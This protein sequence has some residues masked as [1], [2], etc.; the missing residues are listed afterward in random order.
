MALRPLMRALQP[1]ERVVAFGIAD[2]A[3]PG[4][5]GL[6]VLSGLLPIGSMWSRRLLRRRRV[7]VLTDRRLVVLPPDRPELSERSI[8]W[9]GEF[10]LTQVELIARGKGLV[11]VRGPGVRFVARVRGRWVGGELSTA[12]P[13]AVPESQAR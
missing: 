11:E 6:S 5:S 10:A 12:R 1:G 13:G 9:N 2:T 7:L 8:R 3:G 4:W